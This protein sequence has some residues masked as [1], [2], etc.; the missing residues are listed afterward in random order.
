MPA[1]FPDSPT[2][3]EV[4]SIDDRSWEW[5]GSTWNANT[6]PIGAVPSQLVNSDVTLAT[7][8]KYFVDTSAART[9]TLPASP[10]LGDEVF[11]YDSTGQAS[12]NN[13]TVLRNGSLIN[14]LSD[15]AII[16]VD[17]SVSIFTYTGSTIGWR[18]E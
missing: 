13:I 17:Q 14:T 10:V 12:V 7:N 5:D 3:G 4:F 15:D 6:L 1:D 9:L 8:K 11:I 16:D 2:L 18:F